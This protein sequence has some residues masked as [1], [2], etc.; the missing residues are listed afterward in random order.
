VWST[1]YTSTILAATILSDGTGASAQLAIHGNVYVPKANV[2][3]AA[4]NQGTAKLRGG[5]VAASVALQS[6]GTNVED[7][8]TD[9][10]T[11]ERQIVVTSTVNRVGTEKVV[12]ATA[13][14]RVANDSVRTTNIDSWV[15]SNP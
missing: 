2:V 10:G 14:V 12:S 1:S 11:G 13:V 4:T 7:I 15:V 9:T 8:S 6:A 5:L 3:L